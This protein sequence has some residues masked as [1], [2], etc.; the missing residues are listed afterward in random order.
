MGVDAGDLDGDGDEDLLVTNLDHESSTLYANLGSGLYAD[1]TIEAGL[2]QPSLG[3]TGFG[4]RFLDY[5]NDGSLDLLVVN[6]SVRLLDNRIKQHNQ[7]FRNDGTGRFSDVTAT[8]GP[9]FKIYDVSRGAA[10]GDL[11]NDGDTDVVVFNNGG[12]TR[13]LLNEVGNRR[14]WLGL[15]VIDDRH[16]RD[17]LQARIE[18]VR[19]GGVSSWRRVHTDGSYL[20]ASDPRVLI[21][22]GAD[23]SPR[24]IRVHWAGGRVEEFPDLAVDRYWML[25]SGKAPRA[26]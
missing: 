18:V 4:A 7:V 14:H 9:A 6:G 8:A 1:R 11:D 16:R 21:G 5:D 25:E 23:P 15:G 12:P 10:V 13:V 19:R 20:S 17:A 3:F 24:T 26:P 22:L 2:L